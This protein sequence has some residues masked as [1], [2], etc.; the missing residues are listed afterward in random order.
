MNIEELDEG[1]ARVA[2]WCV[3]PEGTLALGDITLAQKIA[4]E[5]NERAALAIAGRILS[6]ELGNGVRPL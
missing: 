1:G 3:H 4:L 5:T 6:S 2:V